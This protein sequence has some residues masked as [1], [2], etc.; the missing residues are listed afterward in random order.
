MKY[1]SSLTLLTLVTICLFAGT[2]KADPVVLT[3]GSA[4]TQAGVGNVN[5][6]GT[7]FSINYVGDIPPGV[8]RT[9]TF[10]SVTAAIG[11]PIVSFNGAGSTFFSGS[12]MFNE[13]FLTGRVLAFAT[14]DDLFFGRSPLFTADF[15][16]SGFLTITVFPGMVPRTQFTIAAVPEPSALLL[17]GTGLSCVIAWRRR[18]NRL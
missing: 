5:L 9:I 6:V 14:M 15:S 18:R 7:N 11:V 2:A 8:T 13:S 12:L 10:N 17:L 16:G 4:S 3:G 1:I